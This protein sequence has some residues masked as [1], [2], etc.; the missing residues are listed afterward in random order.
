M[1]VSGRIYFISNPIYISEK[2]SIVEAIIETSEQYPQ[3]ILV[4]C[5]NSRIGLF[6]EFEIDDIVTVDFNLRGRLYM[7]QQKGYER[8]FT[9][10]D[11]WKVTSDAH[12]QQQA[13]ARQR[14]APAAPQQQQQAAPVQQ[15][16]QQQAQQ[17][18]Q[19]HYAQPIQNQPQQ[20]QQP[21]RQRAQQPAAQQQQQQAPQ[22][23]AGRQ[24]A[25][26]QQAPQAPNNF[27]QDGDTPEDD[28]P[29]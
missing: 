3:H 2:F 28:L 19:V 24:R 23:A 4:Q 21:Q 22:P 17:P 5:S 13:Q 14:T 12:P 20:T 29:F 16:P 27:T 9:T 11:A 15:A 26:Q 8:A 25:A 6:D 10:L 7:D 18:A 1:Q